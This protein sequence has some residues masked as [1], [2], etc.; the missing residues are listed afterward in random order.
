LSGFG[1]TNGVALYHTKENARPDHLEATTRAGVARRRIPDRFKCFEPGWS[2]YWDIYLDDAGVEESVA[3][4]ELLDFA[5]RAT[6]AYG[7]VFYM[8]RSGGPFYYNGGALFGDSR[9][10]TGE[11]GD[12]ICAWPWPERLPHV[13]LR[14]VYPLNFLSRPYLDLPVGGTTLER[15]VRADEP[16]RGTLEPLNE[17]VTTWRPPVGNIPLLREALFRAGAI[18]YKGFF[19]KGPLH[20]DFSRPFV[21]PDAI[22]EI[23]RASFYEGR[24]PK[25]TR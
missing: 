18:F 20:R 17:S 3:A 13:L 22:P 19:D 25:I 11:E 6:D 4:Q 16:A 8:K 21:P 2:A 10:R 15:W 9:Q 24:D 12:N 14:D 5:A 7:Y 23:F 1:D